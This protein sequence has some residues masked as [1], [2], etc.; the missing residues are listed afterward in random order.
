M[1]STPAS[2]PGN[3]RT[4]RTPSACPDPVHAQRSQP[5]R[6]L[7]PPTQGS[8]APEKWEKLDKHINRDKHAAAD[9]GGTHGIRF[10][11]RDLFMYG[12]KWLTDNGGRSWDTHQMQ[13]K[14]SQRAIKSL[15]TYVNSP[16]NGCG[17]RG[18]GDVILLAQAKY[19]LGQSAPTPEEA[20]QAAF[21]KHWYQDI[22]WGDIAEGAAWTAAAAA[23]AAASAMSGGLVQA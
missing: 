8:G 3:P 14:S 18:P 7:N 5:T 9:R 11:T 6:A 13:Y 21:G 22:P 1:D 12:M 19:W 10:R 23:A 2:W 20:L 17:P 15:K 4:S 16:R